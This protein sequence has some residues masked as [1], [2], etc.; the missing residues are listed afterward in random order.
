MDNANR[1][2]GNGSAASPPG[3][4]YLHDDDSLVLEASQVL[5]VAIEQEHGALTL[6]TPEHQQAI[7]LHLESCGI[8]VPAARA[9]RQYLSF[10]ATDMLTMISVKGVPDASQFDV[11]L[12]AIV[13][14]MCL[15]HERVSIFGEMAALLR[16]EGRKAA[17]AELERWWKQLTRARPMLLYCGYP[18]EALT[19]PGN[20]AAFRRTCLEQCRMLQ[21]HS[22]S[23]HMFEHGPIY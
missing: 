2:G 9:R 14:P 10:D 20:A 13:E 6:A 19:D 16:M 17:A 15:R 18:L 1:P 3:V 8:D 5:C 7:D 11:V 12:P 23:S 4:Q 22:L 21:Y